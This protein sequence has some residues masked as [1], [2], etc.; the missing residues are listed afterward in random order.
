MSLSRNIKN[1]WSRVNKIDHKSSQIGSLLA[2]GV[3]GQPLWTPKRY[4]SLA[5]EGYQKNVIVY[6]CVN[7]IARGLASV[8]WLLYER[9]KQD[10]HEIETHPLLDLLQNMHSL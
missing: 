5:D 8:P 6:R 9:K 10:E 1:L 2:C 4:D 3:L 7:L